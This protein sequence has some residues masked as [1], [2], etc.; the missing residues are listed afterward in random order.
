M[1]NRLADLSRGKKSSQWGGVKSVLA[2]RLNSN[3][4][5]TK[6][7]ALNYLSMAIFRVDKSCWPISPARSRSV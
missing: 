6:L 5:V 4:V 7:F 3:G 1:G 2:K